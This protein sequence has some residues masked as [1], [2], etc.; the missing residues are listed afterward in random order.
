[1]L[2][3]DA[4]LAHPVAASQ[5]SLVQELPSLHANAPVPLQTPALQASVNVHASLSLHGVPV[6]LVCVQAPP[7]SQPSWVHGLLSL[8]SGPLVPLQTPVT[9][10]SPPEQLLPSSHAVSF[11]KS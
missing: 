4:V 2:F 6:R 7:E 5:T 10:R 3:A 9:H 8:Q 1:V 11:G